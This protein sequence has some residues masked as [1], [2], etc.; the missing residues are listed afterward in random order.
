VCATRTQT[1]ATIALGLQILSAVVMFVVIGF[2]MA[3]IATNFKLC[4]GFQCYQ[5]SSTSYSNSTYFILKQAFISTELACSVVH[6]TL[7]IMYIILF[8]KCFK[9]LPRVHPLVVGLPRESTMITRQASVMS[10]TS[11]HL[12]AVSRTSHPPSV[13]SARTRVSALSAR[14]YYGAQKICPNC[15]YVSAYQPEENIVECPRCNYQ[16]PFVEHAQQW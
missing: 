4:I 2:L 6:I 11:R 10:R 5:K 9:Q 12:S 14:S 8:V 15:K 16:S 3:F 7:T 1:K 13:V